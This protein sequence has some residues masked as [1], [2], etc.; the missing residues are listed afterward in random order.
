MNR[1][2]L[3]E[4]VA[5][6][7]SRRGALKGLFATTAWLAGCGGRAP[8]SPMSVETLT[9]PPSFGPVSHEAA[10]LEALLA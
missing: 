5:L 8:V 1:P 4:L 2:T 9:R 10:E 3:A 7:V 6:D